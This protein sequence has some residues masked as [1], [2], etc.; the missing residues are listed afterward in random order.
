MNNIL[1]VRKIHRIKR[2][3]I[4]QEHANWGLKIANYTDFI[5]ALRAI[6]VRRFDIQ[7]QIKQSYSSQNEILIQIICGDWENIILRI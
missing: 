7:M 6:W 2:K 3:I 4:T 5:T 1:Q